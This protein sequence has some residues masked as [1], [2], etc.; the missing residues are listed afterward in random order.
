MQQAHKMCTA[1]VKQIPRRPVTDLRDL[2]SPVQKLRKDSSSKDQRAA[3]QPLLD[4]FS[5]AW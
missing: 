1:P 4:A 5:M 3:L 2:R